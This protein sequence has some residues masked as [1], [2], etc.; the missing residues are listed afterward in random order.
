MAIL[1]EMEQIYPDEKELIYL[2]GDWSYHTGQYTTAAKYL[3]KVLTMAPQDERALHH[4]ALT[5]QIGMGNYEKMFEYAKRYASVNEKEGTALIGAYYRAIGEYTLAEEY[6]EKVLTLDSTHGSVIFNLVYMNYE[7]GRYDKMLEYAKRYASS[8]LPSISYMRL[9]LAYAATGDFNTGLRKLQEARKMSPKNY[10]ISRLIAYLYMRQGQYD[11][12]E[13][14]LLTLV[15]ERQPREARFAGYGGFLEFYPY[16]G[17]YREALQSCDKLIALYSQ[18]NDLARVADMHL[19]KGWLMAEGW[20][21]LSS[22]RHEVEKTFQFQDSISYITYWVKLSFAY[23]YFGDYALAESTAKQRLSSITWFYPV[24]QSFIHS[25]KHEC[26]KAG[27]F[28]STAT[29]SS[30]VWI[31]FSVL[32]HLAKCQIKERQLDQ[33]VKSLLNLQAIK[34]HQW[35]RSVYYTKS[36]C[37]LGKVYEEKGATKLAIENYEKFLKLWKDA[38][39]DLPELIDAKRRLTKLKGMT[40]K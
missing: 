10:D 30:P 7:I 17:K 5:Y 34:V 37:L 40:K 19:F 12:A 14:E 18:T 13:T 33:A 25:T 38:D 1:R 35:P 4:L 8:V 39:E 16:L 11:K 9:G 28:A 21:D 22:F 29:K 24:I 36:F 2:I 31:R 23:V 6:F 32:Y 3:E 26:T 20:N 27:S 15:N